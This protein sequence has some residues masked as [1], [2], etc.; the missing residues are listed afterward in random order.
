MIQ[1]KIANMYF[2][3]LLGI[4]FPWRPLSVKSETKFE[5]WEHKVRSVDLFLNSVV[6]FLIFN[7]GISFASLYLSY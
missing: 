4:A 6:F 1:M 3:Q 7:F 2:I 5:T